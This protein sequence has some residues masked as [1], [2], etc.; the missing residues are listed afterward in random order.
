MKERHTKFWKRSTSLQNYI[1]AAK[2]TQEK[3][4]LDLLWCIYLS[5]SWDLVDTVTALIKGENTCIQ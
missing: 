1:L 3:K 4:K 2:R 5:Y